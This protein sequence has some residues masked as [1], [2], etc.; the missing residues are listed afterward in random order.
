MKAP[1]IN[2]PGTKNA[3]KAIEGTL[4][5]RAPGGIVSA[6]FRYLEQQR[7]KRQP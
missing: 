6:T 5:M 2:P 4:T 7:K 1:K 3:R